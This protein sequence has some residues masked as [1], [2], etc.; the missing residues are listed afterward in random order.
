M[1][2][3]CTGTD[4]KIVSRDANLIMVASKIGSPK[5][6]GGI[7]QALCRMCHC[8]LVFIKM[9]QNRIKQSQDNYYFCHQG[10]Y[11]SAPL[12]QSLSAF[13]LKEFVLNFILHN[14]EIPKS[15][16]DFCNFFSVFAC[17]CYRFPIWELLFC[18]FFVFH[19]ESKADVNRFWTGPT[20]I[21]CLMSI[22]SS[23]VI[24]TFCMMLLM[25]QT[26]NLCT[27]AVTLLQLLCTATNKSY[28]SVV[29]TSTVIIVLWD[30]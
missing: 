9:S 19:T 16:H 25:S 2:S 7:T 5:N 14:V 30:R 13:G 22:L 4:Y 26:T 3:A 27:A 23:V 6:H 29:I 28:L 12:R 17:R 11:H 24:L 8:W 18:L 15:W 10:K 20:L 1:Q 21:P